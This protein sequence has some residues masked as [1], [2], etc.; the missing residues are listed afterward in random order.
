MMNVLLFSRICAKTG[1]G[2]HMRQLAEELVRQGQS[3][4]I[5]SSNNEQGIIENDQ[6]HV[7]LAP[8]DIKNTFRMWKNLITL[9]NI[10]TRK[11]IDIVH[12]HHRMAA[13]YMKIYN[14]FWDVPMVYTLHLAPVPCDL[15]HRSLTYVGDMG[16]GVSTEVVNFMREKL[17][18][19]KEKTTVIL[20]GVTTPNN[21]GGIQEMSF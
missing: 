17:Q 5:L 9:R 10:I 3:V 7:I 15:F 12:C 11:K 6:L 8:F 4:W 2:G 14:M 20:N 19:P 1:V 16:I 13:L 21:W 18:I